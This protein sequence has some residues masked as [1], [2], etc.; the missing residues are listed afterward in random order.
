MT[1]GARWAGALAIA[2]AVIAMAPASAQAPA[3]SCGQTLTQQLRRLSEECIRDLMSYTASLPEGSATIFSEKD[4]YFVKL[5]K[6]GNGLQGEAV[7]KQ[8]FPL[9]K[10]DTAERLKS[11]GWMAPDVE[12]GGFKKT[13]AEQDLRSGKAAKDVTN[14]LQAYGMAPGEAISITVSD[15]K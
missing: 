12:F 3:E 8:N 10:D 11:L 2:G 15:H 13:F 5:T 6:A 1:G 9:M 14:A 4:K 7:S